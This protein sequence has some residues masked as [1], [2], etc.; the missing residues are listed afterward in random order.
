MCYQF[1]RVSTLSVIINICSILLYLL[2][3]IYTPFHEET[4]SKA[5]KAWMSLANAL[6][7]LCVIIVMTVFLIVLYKY[8]CYKV[9]VYDSCEVKLKREEF[10]E[11]V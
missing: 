11:L 9:R 2:F 3:R 10:L 8:R 4:E 6:I 7:L 5:T 1:C